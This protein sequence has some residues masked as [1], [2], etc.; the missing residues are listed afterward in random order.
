ME[1]A[2]AP[3]VPFTVSELSHALSEI[4]LNRAVARPFAPGI[5][6][7]NHGST[8]APILHQILC[9]WWGT[10][11][12][13]IPQCW[14]D[15]WMIMLGKPQKPPH[16]Y[17]NLR[18]IALQDPVGKALVGLLIQCACRDAKHHMLPWPLW[19][20]MPMRSTLDA[21]C[22]VISLS[23]GCTT[24]CLSAANSACT[25]SCIADFSVLWWCYSHA[26]PGKGL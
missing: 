11:P 26:G 4:P 3:G 17:Y 20:Y 18:P 5:A 8:I 6:W 13:F 15:G 16:S 22:R 19:A 2:Q 12:P 21:I 7:R 24:D 9:C 25:R 14:K 23:P 1:F 10:N